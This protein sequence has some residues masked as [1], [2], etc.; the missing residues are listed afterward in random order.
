[1]IYMKKQILIC[2]A[3]V[4]SLTSLDCCEGLYASKNIEP[5]KVV[6][7]ASEQFIFSFAPVAKQVSPAVVNIY[8]L[9]L[10]QQKNFSPLLDDPIFRHFLGDD[11]VSGG[12]PTRIQRS[13]GSGVIVR[14]N[15]VIITNNHVIKNA[16]KIKV[17]MH[18]GREYEATVV[19]REDRTDLA[20]LK[21]INSPNNLPYLKLHDADSLEVGDIVLAVGNPF[22]L[23]QTVTSGIVSA[24]ARTQVGANDFRSYIQIDASINPGN[25]GGALVDLK[26]RLVGINTAILSKSGGSIGIGFAIPSNLV[27]PVLESVDHGGKVVRAW[28]G[29]A[30]ARITKQLSAQLEQEHPVGVVVSEIFPKGPAD[31]ANIE[32]GD[33]I[34]SVDGQEINSAQNFN[35]RVV[36]RPVGHKAIFQIIKKGRKTPED[37]LVVMMTPPGE[38]SKQIRLTGRHPLSGATIA[39]ITPYLANQLGLGIVENGVVVIRVEQDAVAKRLGLLPGDIIQNFNGGPVTNTEDLV[40]RLTRERGSWR[41]KIKRANQTYDILLRS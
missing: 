35:F 19:S 23:G 31:L 3:V 9:S 11:V 24:L 32:V 10:Q 25:S 5:V 27:A 14:P 6:P 26:G 4:F 12:S 8:A 41:I 40:R 36:T 33:V 15:G 18:D 7:K 21:L 28:A 22:G 1:M 20:A 29:V 2:L 30:V 37:V 39:T 16:D 13:L 17:V 34:I 38:D